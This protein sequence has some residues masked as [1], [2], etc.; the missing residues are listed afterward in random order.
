MLSKKRSAMV[1]AT[2]IGSCALAVF[3]SSCSDTPSVFTGA[4]GTGGMDGTGGSMAG[5]GGNMAGSGGSMAGS[6]GNMAGSGGSTGMDAGTDAACVPQVS[7][8][9]ASSR[10]VDVIILIDNSGSMTDEILAVQA[11]INNALAAV[12]GD[13]GVD[14]RII[15]VARHG[16]AG[17][18]QSV[19]ISAPL[20]GTTCN[21]IPAQ[22]AQNPPR[23]QHYS[24]EI[25]SLNGL[26]L[27]RS[28]FNGSPADDFGVA[29][30]GWSAWLRPSAFKVI[31]PITDDGVTCNTNMGLLDDLDT[32]AGG[33][34]VGDAFDTALLALSPMQFGTAASRKY[35]MHSLIGMVEN[36]AWQPSDPIQTSIC[37]TAV[38]PGTGYQAISKITGGLRFGLCNTGAY[39]ATFTTI[40]Q[41]AIKRATVAC[42]FPIPTPQPGQSIDPATIILQYTPSGGTPQKFT[43]VAGAAD[44]MPAAFYI[45]NSTIKLCPS[46][47]ATLQSDGGATIDVLHGCPL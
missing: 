47:C 35:V 44:C 17:T 36:G 34:M 19:C 13:A 31:I 30:Q 15:M 33:N 40:A 6:G 5:S 7:P 22:P 18:G 9:P 16:D 27:L 21:P 3:A 46:A 38:H 25:G 14:Y 4:T 29:P 37:P 41:D 10:Q 45:E 1:M 8:V 43:P 42:N 23:F 39:N 28:T 32:E 2:W 12:I 26:C 24:T 20:S 11:N